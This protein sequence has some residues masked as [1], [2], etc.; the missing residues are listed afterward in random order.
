MVKK[1]DRKSSAGGADHIGIRLWSACEAWKAEFVRAMNGAGHDWF[2]P[3]RATLLGFVPRA[4]VRQAEL[5]AR[6]G[7]SKQAV[8]QLIDGLEAEGI[9][10]R[11]SDP[12]DRRSRIVRHTL[13]GLAALKDADGIKH[14]IE[15]DYRRRM[16]SE[17]FKLLFELLGSVQPGN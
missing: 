9:L 17:N 14:R 5:I 7:I 1:L 6:M 2:S 4:G 16:G 15:T 13:K 8:Q 3:S 12:H 10:E 11:I